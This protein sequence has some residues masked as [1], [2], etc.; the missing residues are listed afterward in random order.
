MPADVYNSAVDPLAK[1]E[2][3]PV[4]PGRTAI[5]V[6]KSDTLDVTNASGDNAPTYAKALWIGVTG[7]VAVVL[8]GDQSASGAGKAVTF[9][10]V[11]VGLFEVQVRRVMSTNTT[12]TSIVGLYG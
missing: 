4:N 2:A 5:A 1:Y 6:T 11:P 3:G 12:A 9:I 7:N 10:G 8:A